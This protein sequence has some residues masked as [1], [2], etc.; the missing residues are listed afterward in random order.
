MLSGLTLGVG[1]E[2]GHGLGGFSEGPI[3]LV[4]D[5]DPT[6]PVVGPMIFYLL[7]R[8]TKLRG[9]RLRFRTTYV[10]LIYI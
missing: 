7:V 5:E 3:R 6:Q 9:Q 8:L 1:E 4:L 10:K 2:Q